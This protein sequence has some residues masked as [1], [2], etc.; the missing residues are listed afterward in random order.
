ML[1]TVDLVIT[2]GRILDTVQKALFL[3]VLG[4]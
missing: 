1:G 4:G 3:L 2:I